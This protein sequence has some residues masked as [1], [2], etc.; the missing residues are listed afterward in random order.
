MQPSA[1]TNLTLQTL[2]TAYRHAGIQQAATFRPSSPP[3]SISEMIQRL[4]IFSAKTAQPTI[5]EFFAG[6]DGRD[7]LV[8]GF[9]AALELWKRGEL[10]LLQSSQ[11]TIV[12]E[13][14]AT[15]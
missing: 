7:E 15:S 5:Q 1:P 12:I 2:Q 4:K 6:L 10:D 13:N 8:A 3:P 11:E 9:L 14:A